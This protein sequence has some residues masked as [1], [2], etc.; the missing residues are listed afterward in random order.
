MQLQRTTRLEP[1]LVPHSQNL[2]WHLCLHRLFHTI[3]RIPLHGTTLRAV[4]QWQ[5]VGAFDPEPAH[6][7]IGRTIRPTTLTAIF[8]RTLLVVPAPKR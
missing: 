1:L 3:E 2:F 8:C 5:G 7:R 6:H 4:E